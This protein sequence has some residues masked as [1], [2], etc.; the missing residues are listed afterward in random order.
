MK[1]EFTGEKLEMQPLGRRRVICDFQGGTLS[2]DAGGLLLREVESRFSVISR[3]AK[4]FSGLRHPALIEHS[5][6]VPEVGLDEALVLRRVDL[7]SFLAALEAS[8]RRLT[9]NELQV[10]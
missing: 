4:C 6:E 1:T 3:M 7:A 2:S 10:R 5:V 9:G 8:V